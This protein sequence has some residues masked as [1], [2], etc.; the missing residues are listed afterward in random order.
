[1]RFRLDH[2]T[3]PRTWAL[4]GFDPTGLGFWAEVRRRGYIV[5][6][7]DGLHVLGG[8]TTISGVLALLVGHGFLEGDDLHEAMQLLPHVD[9]ADIEGLDVRR[10]AEVIE[11]LRGAASGG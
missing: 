4:Y 7:Y 9:A 11:R 6:A 8:R 1:M 2:P 3:S 10:A 5:S